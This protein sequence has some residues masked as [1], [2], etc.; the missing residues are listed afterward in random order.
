VLPFL[1]VG[2]AGIA[3]SQVADLLKSLLGWR[4]LA[5]VKLNVILVLLFNLRYSSSSCLS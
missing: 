4:I 5:W 1:L 3:W 2:L